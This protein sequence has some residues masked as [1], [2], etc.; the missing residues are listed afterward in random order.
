M[1]FNANE[2][3]EYYSNVSSTRHATII[4]RHYLLDMVFIVENPEK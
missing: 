4:N 3:T 1:Y 2:L